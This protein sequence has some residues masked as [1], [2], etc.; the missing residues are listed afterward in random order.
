MIKAFKRLKNR[1][2]ILCAQW[3]INHN[4]IYGESKVNLNSKKLSKRFI[5]NI[6]KIKDNGVTKSLLISSKTDKNSTDLYV[7]YIWV[8]MRSVPVTDTEIESGYYQLMYDAFV[9]WYK[10]TLTG[11]NCKSIMFVDISK[12]NQIARLRRILTLY[13]FTVDVKET[14]EDVDFKRPYREKEVIKIIAYSR[15]T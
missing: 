4:R 10:F 13:G 8:N 12:D 14:L 7:D 3:I 11:R 6:I 5:I 15:T 9:Q 1:I 2:R